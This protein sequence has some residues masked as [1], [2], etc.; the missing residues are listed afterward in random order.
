MEIKFK[1][2]SEKAVLPKRAYAGDAG[3]DL[4]ATKITTTINECG[5]LMLTYHT[6]LAVEIPEGFVGLLFPRSSIYKKSMAQTNSV[7]VI[8]AG[9]RGEVMVVFKTTTDVIP[10]IYKEGDRFCQLVIVPIPQFDI[11]EVD[12]LSPSERGENG[13][14]SSNNSNTEINHNDNEATDEQSNSAE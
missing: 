4:T 13:Y 3:M 12:E 2:L 11:V 6:D 1:K 8:D 5:Q 14:G 9:Y 7:G 10:S